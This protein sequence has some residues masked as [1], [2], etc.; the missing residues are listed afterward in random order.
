[1][2]GIYFHLA[3][4]LTESAGFQLQAL[5]FL[6]SGDL[7]AFCNLLFPMNERNSSWPCQLFQRLW[8]KRGTF[9][10]FQ[11]PHKCAASFPL[12]KSE[13]LCKIETIRL[14]SVEHL[15]LTTCSWVLD[16]IS[17]TVRNGLSLEVIYITNASWQNTVGTCL[18]FWPQV[19]TFLKG[20]T[21]RATVIS[22]T[23]FLREKWK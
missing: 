18:L 1:M 17:K 3:N 14:Y 12:L 11:L 6:S 22:F 20:P 19:Q 15:L 2:F 16:D 4:L 7:C 21:L 8:R 10:V 5:E 13:G 9:D 23:L